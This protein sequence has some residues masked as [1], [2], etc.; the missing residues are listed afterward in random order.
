MRAARRINPSVPGAPVIAT[1]AFPCFPGLGDPVPF[2]VL[3][4][5]F[6][7]TVRDPQQRE[8]PQRREVSRSE[9]VGER[10]VD[11]FRL[12]DVAVGHAPAQ[13]LRRH[14]DELDRVGLPN[15]RIRDG[16]ALLGT[17]DAFDDVVQRLEMLDVE[18][19][20]HVDPAREQLL[21]VLPSLRIAGTRS[22][23]VGELVDERLRG[24]AGEDGV[25]VHLF[26]RRPA[27][28][29]RPALDDLEPVDLLRGPRTPVRLDVA[30][31][32]IPAPL[33]A[34][35][36]LVQH[37]KGLADS[38]RRPEV[39]AQAPACHDY[40]TRSLRLGASGEMS[41]VRSP[42]IPASLLATR[43]CRARG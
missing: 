12:V 1:G 15:D 26:Q 41:S 2:A 36:T 17:G 43:A 9:V 13:R 20:D 35:A 37:R 14:V 39:D 38:G 22:I 23:R 7:D 18:R 31:D 30:D 40:P 27:V 10:R 29:D 28:L 16:L 24:L 11:P 5:R 8:L 3:A 21:D 32:D 25:D 34:A 19:R 33:E 42:P 4:Q 6:V